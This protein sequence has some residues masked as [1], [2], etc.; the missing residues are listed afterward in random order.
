MITRENYEE[1][2]LLYVDD[3]LSST[4]RSA[5]EQF[6]ADNPDLKEEWETLLQCRVQA[7][8]AQA[9][10]DRDDLF[11][12]ESAMLSYVDGEL[13]RQESLELED[14][15]RHHPGA[16]VRLQ[17]L[18]MTV[19]QPD[20]SVVFPDKESLYHGRQ[21]RAVVLPWLTAGVAAAL[22][23]AVALL[24]VPHRRPAIPEFSYAKD[25]PEVVTPQ[26]SHA[27]YPAKKDNAM[28]ALTTVK[29]SA[30]KRNKALASSPALAAGRPGGRR[31][32]RPGG[33]ARVIVAQPVAALRLQAVDTGGRSVKTVVT[34]TDAQMAGDRPG[35]VTTIAAVNIPKEQSSFATQALLQEQLE[36]NTDNSIADLSATPVKNKLRGIFRKVGRAFG[37]TAD[38]D[39]DGQRQ[40]LISAFQV[41]LK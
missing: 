14:W 40:V 5:V 18:R 31:N 15:V 13:G 17:Q 21:K 34:A 33:P 20:P 32:V 19:S 23:G 4:V 37:K 12:Y 38:R 1:F 8:T 35:S 26:A 39:G 16:A 7:D 22:L 41:A 25:L 6:V 11:R 2:F 10:P 3:E 36:D 9:F 24:L 30:V 29:D 28:Q 27:L